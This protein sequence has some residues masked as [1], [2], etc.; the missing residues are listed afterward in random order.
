MSRIVKYAKVHT[1][2]FAPGLPD[3]GQTLPPSHKN[4]PMTMFDDGTALN[5]EITGLGGKK[6]EIRVPYGNVQ[7]MVMGPEIVQV[8]PEKPALVVAKAK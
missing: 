1:N 2:I 7:L 6:T 3:L 5:V 8:A 4:V